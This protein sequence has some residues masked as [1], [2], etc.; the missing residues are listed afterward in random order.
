MAN[1]GHSFRSALGSPLLGARRSRTMMVRMT[2]IT[3]S[4][5]ASTRPLEKPSE[6]D[7]RTSPSAQTGGTL[8]MLNRSTGRSE[9]FVVKTW[10][11]LGANEAPRGFASLNV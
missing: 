7:I 3:P 5:N 9:S 6:L 2:A 1:D 4:E 8:E 10:G 11:K